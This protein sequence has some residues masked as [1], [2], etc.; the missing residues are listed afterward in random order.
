MPWVSCSSATKSSLLITSFPVLVFHPF[1]FQP[2]TQLVI[3][4]RKAHSQSTE[5]ECPGLLLPDFPL[6]PTLLVFT[7]V[8][9]LATGP[10]RL[11]S[12]RGHSPGILLCLSLCSDW[13][14]PT[15]P[16]LRGRLLHL[17]HT[18]SLCPKQDY[19]SKEPTAR[20]LKL[21]MHIY[22]RR[23][24]RAGTYLLHCPILGAWPI[25]HAYVA[26][27]RAAERAPEPPAFSLYPTNQLLSLF[28]IWILP[29]DN[30]SYTRKKYLFSFTFTRK[31]LEVQCE[32]LPFIVNIL[33]V[34]RTNFL[35]FWAFACSMALQ[36]ALKKQAS[37]HAIEIV[38][39]STLLMF[40]ITSPFKHSFFFCAKCN[41]YML[42]VK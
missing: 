41:D 13:C 29:W 4:T 17:F 25:R 26:N 39:L 23:T 15:A 34:Y 32:S 2:W 18:P 37:H 7:A 36:A 40:E 12:G 21:L 31:T 10:H 1:F 24:T 27:S 14:W 20:H 35:M 5:L 9:G 11:Y 16:S 33:S 42:C 38:Q 3:P 28:A 30:T 6:L 22:S 8:C 19:F